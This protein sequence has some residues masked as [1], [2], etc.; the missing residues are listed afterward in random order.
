M[1][2]ALYLAFAR[3]LHAGLGI[4]AEIAVVVTLRLRCEETADAH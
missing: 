4:T 1:H 3:E 2:L